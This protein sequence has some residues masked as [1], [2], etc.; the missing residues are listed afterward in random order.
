MAKGENNNL[1]TITS[2]WIKYLYLTHPCHFIY[3]WN[4]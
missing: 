4:V 3:Q 1:R 2:I